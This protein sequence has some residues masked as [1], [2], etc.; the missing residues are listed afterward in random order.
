MPATDSKIASCLQ[1]VPQVEAIYI[2]HAGEEGLRVLTIVNDENED[3]YERIYRK[4]LQ[5][6]ESLPSILFDFS[7][8]AR[9]GRAINSIVGSNL[10]VWAR[11]KSECPQ[12]KNI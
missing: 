6:A 5:V 8:V 3:V 7:V 1:T 4:E 9:R 11:P 12:F 2:S 10:P